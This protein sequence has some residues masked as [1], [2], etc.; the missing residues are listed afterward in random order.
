VQKRGRLINMLLTEKGEDFK[1]LEEED[2][3]QK[4]VRRVKVV[5]E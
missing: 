3:L 1:S 4:N 5:K 2:M